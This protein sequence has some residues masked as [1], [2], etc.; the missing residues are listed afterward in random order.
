MLTLTKLLKTSVCVLL[1]TFATSMPGMAATENLRLRL[2]ATID[3]GPAMEQ[4]SWSVFR[5][6]TEEVKRAHKHSTRINLPRGKYTVVAR[7]TSDNK[8]IE[9]RRNFFH[10]SDNSLLVVPMD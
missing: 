10:T 4:V 3:N 5:N 8:V 6:G 1:V 7:L 2:I 9:R